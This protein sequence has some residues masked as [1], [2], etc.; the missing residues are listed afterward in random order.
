[1]LPGSGMTAERNQ[2]MEAKILEAADNL[3][4]ERGF[5]MTSTTEIAKEAGCNQAL[6]HYYFRT[7]DRLFEA[8]FE[9]K[10]KLF[11]KA[12]LK[13]GNE[14]LSFEEKLRR[15][16]ETHFDI[17]AKNPRLPFLV[18]NELLTNPERVKAIRSRIVPFALEAYEQFDRELTAAIARGE[19]RP[20]TPLDLIM[21]VISMNVILFVAS[22]V[23]RE[24]MGLDDKAFAKLVAHRRAETVETV[25]RSLKP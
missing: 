23:I 6:V 7:K 15:K 21:N 17:L 5:A 4:S 1:M 12:F 24:V 11:V 22:P 25:L 19:I 20:I 10:L 14:D 13:I 8:I 3:F 2:D 18:I 9:T 16:I